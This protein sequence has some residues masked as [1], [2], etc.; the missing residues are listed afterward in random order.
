[1]TARA[2]PIHKP[3]AVPVPMVFSSIKLGEQQIITIT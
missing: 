2:W 1:L 3:I